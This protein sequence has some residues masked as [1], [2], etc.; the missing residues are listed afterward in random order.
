M[1][2]HTGV[3]IVFITANIHDELIKVLSLNIYYKDYV[4]NFFCSLNMNKLRKK[5]DTKS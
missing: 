1:F 4:L 2:M 3:M 5:F